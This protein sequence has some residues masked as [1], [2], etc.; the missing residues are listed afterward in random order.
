MSNKINYGIDAPKVIR[1]L[2]VAG[3]LCLCVAFFAI[4]CIKIDWL[5]PFSGSFLWTGIGCILYGMLMIWYGRFGKLKHRERLLALHQFKGNEQ[6]LDVGT[7]RGLMMIGAAK[8]LQDGRSIGIDIWNDED[9]S[10]NHVENALQNA[11]LAGVIDKVEIRNENILHTSFPENHF[12]LI[13]SNLCLHNIYNAQQRADACREIFRI[14]KHGGETI[15]SDFRHTAAYR[16][17][18]EELGMET[19]KFGPYFFDTFPAL[20]ILLQKRIKRIA[21]IVM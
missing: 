20:T 9:L 11:R 7:G 18:F 17:T 8:H 15:I 12:D 13:V 6:V 14:L 4:P 1:N 3:V 16:K 19:E 21:R 5:Q 2:I 10:G